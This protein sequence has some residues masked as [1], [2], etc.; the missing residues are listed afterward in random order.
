MFLLFCTSAIVSIA[1]EEGKGRGVGCGVG[2]CLVGPVSSFVG[3][4]GKSEHGGSGAAC[5]LGR[6]TP[7][8]SA[9]AIPAKTDLDDG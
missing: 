8:F 3:C 5:G 1:R 9:G 4:L 6:L 2:F 7:K